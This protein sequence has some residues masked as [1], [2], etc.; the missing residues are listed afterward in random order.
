MPKEE[1]KYL[2]VDKRGRRIDIEIDEVQTEILAYH[3]G[4]K[5]GNFQTTMDDDG[6][7]FAY[8]IDINEEY[9]RAGIGLEMV[10]LAFEYHG[11]PLIPPGRNDSMKINGNYV[12]DSGAALVRA[13]Q[14]RGYFTPFPDDEIPSE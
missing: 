6:Y 13:G 4:E 3:R 7:A 2:F 8:S 14:E 5:I 10:R 9:R 12:T 11:R 1:F